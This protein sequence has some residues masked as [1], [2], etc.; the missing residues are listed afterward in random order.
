MS[1]N[2]HI[3]LV[4]FMTLQ[5]IIFLNPLQSFLSADGISPATGNRKKGETSCCHGSN[6]VVGDQN[7]LFC[8]CFDGTVITKGT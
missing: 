3:T 2:N 7:D 4:C 1:E 8:K 6:A 5:F